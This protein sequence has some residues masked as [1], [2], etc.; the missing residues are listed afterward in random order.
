MA[1]RWSFGKLAGGAYF[2]GLMVATAVRGF[3]PQVT[4]VT[5]PL[6]CEGGSG[7]VHASWYRCL[8]GVK[9]GLP[10]ILPMAATDEMPDIIV[11]IGLTT[12]IYGTL[13][14][15]AVAVGKVVANLRAPSR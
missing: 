7:E 5:A 6:L 8:D 14:F 2:V 12:L 9:S 3:V 4:L 15:A 11:V 1:D 13:L 10:T